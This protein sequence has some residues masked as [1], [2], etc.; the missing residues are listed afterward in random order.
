MT[1]SKLIND[2]SSAGMNADV[3]VAGYGPA[4]ACGAFAGH[5]AGREADADEPSR[6]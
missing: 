4:G 2:E 6:N 1:E 3:V 5:D